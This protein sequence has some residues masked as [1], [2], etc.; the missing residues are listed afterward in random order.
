MA[1]APVG[2]G[3]IKIALILSS[4]GGPR[5]L[6][7]LFSGQ[8]PEDV[9]YI[10]VQRMAHGGLMDVL[11][12]CLR[13]E[14]NRK[15]LVAGHTLDLQPGVIHFLPADR[16][17]TF[18]GAT[19]RAVEA[20]GA[21]RLSLDRLLASAA[22]LPNPL[23]VVVLSGM[24]TDNDGVD[25]LTCLAARGVPVLGSLESQTPVFDMIDQLRLKGLM[26]E[27]FPPKHLLEHLRFRGAAP[28][29]NR[30]GRDRPRFLVA[31]DEES[32]RSVIGELLVA[33]GVDCEYAADGLDALRRIQ[34]GRY[35]ALILDLH[36]PEMDGFRTL[37]A[38]K[39]IDPGL[40]IVVLTGL[41]DPAK[42]QAAKACNVLGVL[43]KPFTFDKLKKLLSSRPAA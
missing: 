15:A 25:G 29:S 30:S 21:P 39:T 16:S 19:L 10:V 11:V 41:E 20:P 17:Y 28:A 2:V 31:D 22:Q 18:V 9:A 42:I 23:A 1:A 33:T 13:E 37:E 36:M 6:S 34:K 43:Q 27:L 40:P 8:V 35:D 5:M 7:S 38:L 32:V 12:E 14:L 24:L 26:G 4:I 3:P